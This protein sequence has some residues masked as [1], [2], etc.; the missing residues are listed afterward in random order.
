MLRTSL[1]LVLCTLVSATLPAQA[2]KSQKIPSVGIQILVHGD[3]EPLPIKLG[4]GH[5]N[6]RA[7]FRVADRKSYVNLGAHGPQ[8]WT[9]DV[10]FFPPKGDGPTTGKANGKGAKPIDP[11]KLEPAE[12][13]ALM[14][15][16]QTINSFEAYLDKVEGVRKLTTN[17]T[18]KARGKYLPYKFYDYTIASHGDM[19]WYYAA[20]VYTLD[21]GE[22]ALIVTL[23]IKKGDRPKGSYAKIVKKMIAS[24]KI[25]VGEID[26][27]NAKRDKFAN[28]PAKV[29]ALDAAKANIAGLKDWNYFTTESYIVIYAWT[30]GEKRNAYVLAK[31]LS[32][33]LEKMRLLYQDYYPPPQGM[34]MP[35]SV[36]RIC[37]TYDQFS[38]YGSSRPGVV[39]W[40]SPSSKELV[41]FKG[42]DKLMRYKGATETVTFHEGWHQYCDSYFG[43]ELHR[44]FDEGHG[45][46]FGS[47]VRRG[48]KWHYK[49]SM[50]R[51]K[52]VQL[53]VKKEDYVSFKDIVTWNKD[54][55]YTNRAAYYY[56]QAYGMIDFLRRGKKLGKLWNQDWA[57]ILETYR[58]TAFKTKDQKAAVE[59]A[60]KDVDFDAMEEA[61][62]AWVKSKHFPKPKK[63]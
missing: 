18:K 61:W 34:K 13:R 53:M 4:T 51:Q 49:G 35:Y 21:A 33:A 41:V 52:W 17:K 10:M 29:K 25:M 26:N 6:L 55:F 44:W 47:F 39:G 37:A 23:P 11:S 60:F 27:D 40:F 43:T 28:T 5:P 48:K 36:L 9:A 12:I 16:A 20:A 31:N 24:G 57:N 50:M 8:P 45:D 7:R 30:K 62:K 1:L 56:A 3:L 42:G 46:F 38:K 15:Q 19:K 2:Y 22:A 58:S 63:N 54:K 59:A 32:G 14:R